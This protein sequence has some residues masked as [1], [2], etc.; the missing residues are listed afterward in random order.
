[1]LNTDATCSAHLRGSSAPLLEEEEEEEE[2]VCV[3]VCVFVYSKDL[4]GLVVFCVFIF[5]VSVRRSAESR[6]FVPSV[7]HRRATPARHT[8]TV[9]ASPRQQSLSATRRR[10]TAARVLAAEVCVLIG[11]GR[12]A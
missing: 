6:N 8:P 4:I 2:E 3:Y 9:S 10:L 1:M 7:S 11:S 5:L 12:A